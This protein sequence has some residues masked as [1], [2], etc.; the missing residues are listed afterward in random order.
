MSK[1]VSTNQK[2]FGQG[3]THFDMPPQSNTWYRTSPLVISLIVLVASIVL[4][5]VVYGG[6]TLS[7]AQWVVLGLCLLGGAVAGLPFSTIPRKKTEYKIP[8]YVHKDRY[9]AMDCE[10]VGIGYRGMKSV[11]ARVSIVNWDLEVVLDTYVQVSEKV[12][13]YRTHVS[14]IK[15]KHLRSENAMPFRSCRET[16]VNLIRDKILV[17]HGLDNDLDVLFMTHPEDM[18]RD[19]AKYRPFQK[20]YNGK[21]RSQKLRELVK[22]Y[23]VKEGFQQGS[24]DSVADAAA[25]MQLFHLKHKEWEQ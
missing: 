4:W 19:T 24:H 15:H 1:S 22:Q 13:D 12:T 17:G 9:L 16:V 2:V 21:W 8:H 11:L 23:L 18:I 14:G 5:F 3:L 10:M 7:R 6:N 25:T 20:F